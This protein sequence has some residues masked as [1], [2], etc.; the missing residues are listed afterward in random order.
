VPFAGGRRYRF[1]QAWGL[2]RPE[3]R[4]QWLVDNVATDERSPLA[5]TDRKQLAEILVPW[6]T[7]PSSELAVQGNLLLAFLSVRTKG[8]PRLA[9]EV[10][11]SGF[12]GEQGDN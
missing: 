11:S 6:K 9:T 1:F 12:D 8:L 5:H 3:D 10:R 2:A 7:A 4:R